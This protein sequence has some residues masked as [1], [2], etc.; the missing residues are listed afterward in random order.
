MESRRKKLGLI[1]SNNIQWI[2]GTYYIINLIHALSILEDNLKPQLI[3]LS[4]E[5][6]YQ[7]LLSQIDYPF[8]SYVLM[9]ENPTSKFSRFVNK[10]TG[11]LIGKKLLVR[12]MKNEIDGIFPFEKNNYFKNIPIDKQIYWIPDFQDKQL[13]QFFTADDLIKRDKRNTWIAYHSRKLVVSSDSVLRDLKAFYP[14][15]NTKVQVVHFAVTHP[16]YD[17]LDIHKLRTDYDLLENYFF[18]PNQ[19]WAHKNQITII[20]AVAELKQQGID[21]V[22][23]FSGKENDN[24]NPDYFPGLKKFVEEN[25]LGENIRFLGFLDREVQLQL[26]KFSKAIIQPSLFEGWSTVIEDAMAMNQT[27]IASDLDVNKE[28]LGEDGIYFERLNFK[29]LANIL[30][31]FKA[32]NH[33]FYYDNRRKRFAYSILKVNEG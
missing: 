25:G 18:A 6:D 29:E 13:P 30:K 3:I 9:D 8:I 17:Y 14:N 16:N 21:V 4:N 19:F 22:V 7:F 11:R 26:M 28:Q 31:D 12:R 1:F 24:R 2:G 20:K 33:N 27:I 5:K 23:A 15:Y 32:R 10:I